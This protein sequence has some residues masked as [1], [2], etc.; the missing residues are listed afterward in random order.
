ME[1]TRRVG[2]FINRK[3]SRKDRGAPNVIQDLVLLII[4]ETA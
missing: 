2:R 4:I 3:F 1:A